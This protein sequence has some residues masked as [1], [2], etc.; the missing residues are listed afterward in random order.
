MSW[1]YFLTN[2]HLSSIFLPFLIYV[3]F[4]IPP[5]WVRTFIRQHSTASW[6]GVGVELPAGRRADPQHLARAT[7]LS[8]EWDYF[9]DQ[10]RAQR[11]SRPL[12]QDHPRE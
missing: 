1:K 2:E 8:E 9:I 4:L 3:S 10:T 6:E 11:P 5:K 12:I 7:V